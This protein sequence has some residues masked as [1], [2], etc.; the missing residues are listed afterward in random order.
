MFENDLRKNEQFNTYVI[1]DLNDVSLSFRKPYS[2]DTDKT[3]NPWTTTLKN[4][5]FFS[6][7]RNCTVTILGLFDDKCEETEGFSKVLDTSNLPALQICGCMK[8][9]GKK[10]I[11]LERKTCG[12]LIW[13]VV[14]KITVRNLG[15]FK[16][17][18]GL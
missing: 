2:I 15:R 10:Y 6:L 17:D 7:V 11:A 16:I 5:S 3:T 12:C 14:L 4:I 13:S 1:N 18:I 9:R 8:K